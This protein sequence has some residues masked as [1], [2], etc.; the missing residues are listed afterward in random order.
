MPTTFQAYRHTKNQELRAA[1]QGISA[2][3]EGGNRLQLP[4]ELPDAAIRRLQG[5]GKFIG[6]PPRRLGA[7]APNDLPPTVHFRI[8]VDVDSHDLRRLKALLF[9]IHIIGR[10]VSWGQCVRLV[11]SERLQQR[12]EALQ[13]WGE[14]LDN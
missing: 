8:R 2:R 5:V 12:R 9:G 10:N 4:S 1:L 11:L 6:A 7:V 3:A 14:F 13:A